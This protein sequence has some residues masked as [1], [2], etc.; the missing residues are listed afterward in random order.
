MTDTA[1]IKI[2]FI[3]VD[4]PDTYVELMKYVLAEMDKRTATNCMR[5]FE[6]S[7]RTSAN[8]CARAQLFSVHA[9]TNK[10]TLCSHSVL[11]RLQEGKYLFSLNN[12][13]DKRKKIIQFIQAVETHPVLWD[14]SNNDYKKRTKT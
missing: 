4:D 5:T 13:L 9:L 6:K 11:L 8:M 12:R 10:I 1:A 7:A 14:T 3:A 2:V